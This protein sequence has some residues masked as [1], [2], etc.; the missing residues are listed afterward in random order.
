[1]KMRHAKVFVA[2]ALSS[3]AF[4]VVLYS[5]LR[6]DVNL[7][8]KLF[9]QEVNPAPAL[10]EVIV[11]MTTPP[12]LQN[13]DLLPPLISGPPVEISDNYRKAIH[14]STAFWNRKQHSLFRK[15]DSKD[16]VTEA[17][18]GDWSKCSAISLESLSTNIQDFKSYPQDY[19]DFLSGMECRDPPILIDQPH[20]CQSEEDDGEVYLL[21][22]IKSVPGSFERR[23]AVRQTWGQEKVYEGGLRVRT[24]FL[25][26]MWSVDDP[27]LRQL[28]S[29]EARHFGDLLQWDFKDT[30][31]NLTLKEN[32]FFRWSLTRCPRVTFV[33]KGDDDVFVNTQT[34]LDYLRT[35][36]ANKASTLY[37]GHIITNTDPVRDHYSKY[38]VPNT[39]Y[40][41]GYSPYAGGGGFLFSGNL[42]TALYRVSKYIPF[43]SID[44]VYTGLCFQAL[45]I[46]PEAHEGFKTFDIRQEDRENA[47]VHKNLILV[48]RRSPQQTLRLWRYV[49]S[50]L[51]TC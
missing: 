35:L 37:L 46:K 21:F 9:M 41:G 16:N 25:L 4:L 17:D 19:Q 40:E 30:F 50:P 1:M 10:Q 43:F 49:H 44:D 20:K 33:F 15:L 22:A 34:M 31:Y 51:L 48:H 36:D 3:S 2:I 5:S 18:T 47:C 42:L 6:S 29:F 27:N 23:Q 32:A 12:V 39:F 7:S 38:Y 14:Q 11:S 13:T 26:G 28:L 8:R 45:G 24:V